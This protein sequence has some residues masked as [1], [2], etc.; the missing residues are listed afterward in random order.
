MLP[1]KV[2]TFWENHPNLKSNL[3]WEQQVNRAS[4]HIET[5]VAYYFSQKE[6]AE[7]AKELKVDAALFVFDPGSRALRYFFGIFGAGKGKIG[8]RVKLLDGETDEPIAEYDAYGTLS[9]GMFG[10]DIGHAYDKCANAIIMYIEDCR[11]N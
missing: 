9:L 1:V 4:Q 6:T 7:D 5:K 2:D 11:K 3:E 10:G 8:Y